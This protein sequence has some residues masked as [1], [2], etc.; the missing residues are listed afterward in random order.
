MRRL[1]LAGANPFVTLYDRDAPTAY[2]SIW[3]VDWSAHGS[4]A[5]IVLWHGGRLRVI[6]DA[7]A[8]GGW[9]ERRFVRH[10]DEATALPS[11]PSPVVET[12]RTTVSVD[13]ASGATAS[14]ADVQL[15]LAEPLDAR[16]VG[17]ADFP[18]D[19]VSHGLSMTVLPC[20]AAAI[21]VDDQPVPGRPRVWQAD[22]R[23]HSSAVT[24]VHESWSG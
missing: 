7:P 19:G 4:G 10:F 20:A 11:W 9:L 13:P 22:G 14:G 6:T 16:P 5:A 18:L 21:T 17:I 23:P 2:A 15:R 8:L 1:V 3:R 12:A 24:A